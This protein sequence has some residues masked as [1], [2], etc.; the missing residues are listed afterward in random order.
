MGVE[1]RL[2]RLEHRLEVLETL[3]RETLVARGGPAAR[4]PSAPAARTPP[5]AA[6]GL[7][8]APPASIPRTAPPAFDA[9]PTSPTTDAP[10][11][12]PARHPPRFAGMATES[13]EADVPGAHLP[14][15]AWIGQRGLLA[16]G[17]LALLLAAGYLLKL[18][19]ERG[20][21]TEA[22]RCIGGAV[23]GFAVGGLGWRLLGRYRTYGAALVGCGAGIVY[24]AVWAAAKL[25][26]L[27]PPATGIGALALVSLSLAAIAY[28]IGV[29]ALGTTA[30]LGAFLAPVLL[31]ERPANADA[32]LG[33][34]GAGALALAV[35]HRLRGAVF[36]GAGTRAG[37]RRSGVAHVRRRTLPRRAGLAVRTAAAGL[38]PAP[39]RG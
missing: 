33:S 9:P 30:A 26:G 27:V 37:G 29:Q 12:R 10:T 25:Y 22:G 17:V 19:F 6:E 36:A 5:A 11:P 18:S 3:M 32:L 21:I 38:A 20:W 24:L 34:L 1:E 13:S 14:S 15:E 23:A 2:D 7:S 16:V 31:G 35:T 39:A 28:G 4:P 8:G